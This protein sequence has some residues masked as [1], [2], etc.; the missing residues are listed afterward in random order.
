MSKLSN[1]KLKIL[2]L[3]KI[4]NEKTD[5][6]HTLTLFVVM[7]ML[8]CS[9]PMTA[10]AETGKT[11]VTG[12]V[13]EFE[14]DSHYEFHEGGTSAKTNSDNTYGTFYISGNVAAVSEKS[15]VPSY[16][17]AD[18][19]LA[20][21]YN[22]G[23]TMLNAD[24]GLWHLIDDKSKKVADMTL[25]SNIMKCAII[26]QTS[27]D[28]KNW[29]DVETIYNAFSD[30]P[31]RTNSIYS[32][33]DVQLINGSYYRA[34][35]VYKLSIR[36][37]DSNLLFINTDKYEYK[38]CSEVY[39]F[40]A[41][42]DGGE[43]DVADSNQTYSLGTK[44]KVDNFDGYFGEKL[45]DNGDVHY[46]WELGNFFVSGYTDEVSD[47]DGNMVFLKNV[48]DK[49]TLWFKLNQNIDGLNGKENLSITADTEGYDQYL[50]TPKMN[51]GRGVLIIRYTD[52]N[53]IKAEPTIYTNYLE[54]NATVGADTKVQLFE[55]GDYEV[56]LDYEITS[57]ELIDKIGH[58]RIFFKFSVRNGNCMV[59]PFDVATGSELTNSSMTEKGFRLDLAKS[60]YLKINLKREMLTDSAEGLVEDTR[61]NGPAKDGAE[62]TDE[63]IYTITVSN[64]YT[65]QFTVKK[66][67]VGTNN[68]LRAYMTTGLS[69]PEINNLVAQ[70]ATI[71]GDGTIRLATIEP[72]EEQPEP[73]ETEPT[74]LPTSDVPVSGEIETEPQ[75]EEKPFPISIFIGIGS[76]IIIIVALGVAKKK[77]QHIE[78]DA[79][80]NE[81]E[82]GL[83]Q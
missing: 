81:N 26:L 23:D 11:E 72:T 22:Y 57:D 76:F 59:Y 37:E 15:G 73:Y 47:T 69:I 51:F 2:Y 32:T 53:N 36:T 4:L 14:K 12:K 71:S 39:E 6:D 43:V 13:Y 60:R 29:V 8:L 77:K 28:R 54:A 25:D 20:F 63:G 38:K 67:Y 46:G 65:N 44:T 68:I 7:I 64:E 78:T 45:I 82:G 48:G 42:T 21:F 33:T 40:Y 16:K 74:T 52:H 35:I 50:E 34:I 31:I 58:Y 24:E 30:T 55:E 56:A 49:V 19:N 80:H 62:Y 5:T 1:Q 9:F 17:V 75:I 10:F 18:G 3:L 61:F 66:I 41:Y 70:G 27:K 79:E 83:E